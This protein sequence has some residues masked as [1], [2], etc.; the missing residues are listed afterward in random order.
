MFGLGEKRL[1]FIVRV[2]LQVCLV[3]LFFSTVEV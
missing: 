2:V 3:W 1:L